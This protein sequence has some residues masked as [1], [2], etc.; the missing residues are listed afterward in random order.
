M[1]AEFPVKD[2]NDK[3]MI[4]ETLN[5]TYT[6]TGSRSNIKG[7]IDH[8]NDCGGFEVYPEEQRAANYDS[9]QDG[10]P[11][12]WEKI[13]GTDPQVADNNGDPDRDGYTNLEDFLNFLA[14]VHVIIAP[15]KSETITLSSFFAGFTAS[16]QYTVTGSANGITTNIDNGSLTVSAAETASGV[17]LLKLTVTDSE[18]TSMT[19]QLGIAV[20]DDTT[21]SIRQ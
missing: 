2:D 10:M 12:W 21:T 14:D 11:D 3:R 17:S 13:T 6:Y 7:Q 18:N 8:E 16:P 15:G 9:D 1:G 19:R 4:H 20:T 5:R